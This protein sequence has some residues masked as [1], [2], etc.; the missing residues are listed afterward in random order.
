MPQNTLHIDPSHEVRDLVRG[1]LARSPY[2]NGREVR[3]EFDRQEVILRGAVRS[4]YHKQVAQE[5]VRRIGGVGAIRNELEVV[6]A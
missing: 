4:Y 3:V 1:V 5:S 6:G 2:F